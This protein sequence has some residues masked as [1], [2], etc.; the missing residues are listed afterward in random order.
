VP[1]APTTGTTLWH[2]PAQLTYNYNPPT[3]AAPIFFFGGG[4]DNAGLSLVQEEIKRVDS[5]IAASQEK[6]KRQRPDS[7]ALVAAEVSLCSEAEEEEEPQGHGGG[8]SASSANMEE[9]WS[10]GTLS[11][12][13]HPQ[14][15]LQYPEEEGRDESGES[16]LLALAISTLGGIHSKQSLRKVIARTIASKVASGAFSWT[17]QEEMQ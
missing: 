3:R 13:S 10:S 8:S 15:L 17:A 16:R 4:K 7:S 5:R 11:A 6:K 9:E 2:T 12:P 14:Q 1:A